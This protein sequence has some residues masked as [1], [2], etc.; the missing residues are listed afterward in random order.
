MPLGRGRGRGG[1]KIHY[2]LPLFGRLS[3]STF[4]AMK[5]LIAPSVLAADYT[6]LAKDFDLVNASEA[7]WF[8]VDVMD[9]VFVPNISFGMMVVKA[10]KKM[11]AKP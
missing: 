5:H 1:Y 7:D 4:A 9:G 3:F 11:A 6:Q 10:M 2:G 8:H